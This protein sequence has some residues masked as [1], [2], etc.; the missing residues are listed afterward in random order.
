MGKKS[1]GD[2]VAKLKKANRSQNNKKEPWVRKSAAS[3]ERNKEIK[4]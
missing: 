3:P 2:C 1:T 4:Y